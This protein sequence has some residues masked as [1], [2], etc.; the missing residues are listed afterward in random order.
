MKRLIML[1][2]L[3]ALSVAACAPLATTVPVPSAPVELADK[4]TLDEQ[5]ALSVEVAYR[6]AVLAAEVAVDSGLLKGEAAARVAVIDQKA[7]RAVQ[8]V[9]AARAAGNAT[10]YAAAVVNARTA[11]DDIVSLIKGERR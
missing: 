1:A 5:A 10:N 3:T 7:Y 9:R 2:A 11:V 4:T 6:A 8:A